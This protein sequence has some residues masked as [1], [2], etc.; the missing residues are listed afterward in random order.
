M[1]RLFAGGFPRDLEESELQE[2]FEQ[3]GQVLAVKIVRDKKTAISRRFGFVDMASQEGADMAMAELHGGSI[4]EDVI[5]VKLADD[6]MAEKVKP[7]AARRKVTKFGKPTNGYNKAGSSYG[8]P[9]NKPFNKRYPKSNAPAGA[10]MRE[11]RPR[12]RRDDTN[13]RSY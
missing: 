5:S 6:R 7:K 11:K 3:Y 8:K 1:I 10:P 9:G 2:I 12:L 13:N 4:D